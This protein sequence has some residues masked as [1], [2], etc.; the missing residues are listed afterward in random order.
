[1]CMECKWVCVWTLCVYVT[2]PTSRIIKNVN[3]A[4]K[5]CKI[6]ERGAENMLRCH[7]HCLSKDTRAMCTALRASRKCCACCCQYQPS[8]MDSHAVGFESEQAEELKLQLSF[9]FWRRV[10]EKSLTAT[11]SA[12]RDKHNGSRSSWECN[13]M[14]KVRESFKL[15]LRAGLEPTSGL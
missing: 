7:R 11:G 10:R 9:P 5:V 8:F 13:G 3:L 4:K 1:M 15:H 2:G 12:N 14:G 6:P